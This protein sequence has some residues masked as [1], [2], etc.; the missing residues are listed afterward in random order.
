MQYVKNAN[1][2][3]K[4]WNL[5]NYVKVLFVNRQQDTNLSS[6]LCTV[7]ETGAIFGLPALTVWHS[8]AEESVVRS[9]MEDSPWLESDVL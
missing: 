7:M 3:R 8:F 9:R 4:R 1:K 5:Q 2:E 6:A